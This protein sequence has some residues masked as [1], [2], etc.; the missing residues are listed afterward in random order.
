MKTKIITLRTF[1]ELTKEEQ[2]KVIEK[3]RYI[4]VDYN[5]WNFTYE[6]AFRVGLEL[7]EF[8]L[9]QYKHAKGKLIYEACGV[10]QNILDQHGENCATYKTAFAFLGRF[11]K[12][13]LEYS[14]NPKSDLL[15]E[16]QDLENSFI[17]AI[18]Q[19]YANIL[20]NEYEYLCSDEAIYETL[21]A[22]EYY[23]NE[24]L[25]IDY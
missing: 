10:A 17:D 5:W 9:Y 20:Q 16:I 7:T 15:E 2:S 8:N 13:D 22:N 18:L 14:K 3:N 19:V 4:N 23:F 24:N 12:L 6:D 25:E 11:K 21:I 1:D